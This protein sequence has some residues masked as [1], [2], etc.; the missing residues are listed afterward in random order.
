MDLEGKVYRPMQLINFYKTG[1]H[2]DIDNIRKELE[3]C[4]QLDTNE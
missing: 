4:V 3:M 2:I 1:K